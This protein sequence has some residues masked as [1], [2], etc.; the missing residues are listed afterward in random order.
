MRCIFYVS[1]KVIKDFNSKIKGPFCSH[2]SYCNIQVVKKCHE[3]LAVMNKCQSILQCTICDDWLHLSCDTRMKITLP[4][5]A[6]ASYFN[7]RKQLAKACCSS[8]VK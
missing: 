3:H 2:K 7:A 4:A 1:R 6:T 8:N 5:S